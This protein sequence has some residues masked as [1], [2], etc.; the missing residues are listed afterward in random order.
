MGETPGF[1]PGVTPHPALG[2]GRSSSGG[3][4]QKAGTRRRTFFQF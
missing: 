2:K 3:P 4:A 1:D